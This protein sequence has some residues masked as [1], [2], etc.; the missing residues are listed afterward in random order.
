VIRLPS[1]GPITARLIERDLTLTEGEVEEE[2]ALPI[3]VERLTDRLTFDF[4]LR[5]EVYENYPEAHAGAQ[6]TR[7]E[8]TLEQ[9]DPDRKSGLDRT[10]LGAQRLGLR[11]V[12]SDSVHLLEGDATDFYLVDVE[13]PGRLYCFLLRHRTDSRVVMEA[14]LPGERDPLWRTDPLGERRLLLASADVPAGSILVRIRQLEGDLRRAPYALMLHPR[15]DDPRGLV[16]SL[17]R[18]VGREATRTKAPFLGSREFAREVALALAAEAKLEPESLS[19]ALLE[20]LGH[21]SEAR[22]LALHLLEVHFP[23]PLASLEEVRRQS[24]DTSGARAGDPE[25]DLGQDATLRETRRRSL[26]AGLL[27]AL[28]C[29][30]D[31]RRIDRGYLPVFYECEAVRTADDPEGVTPLARLRPRQTES[32]RERAQQ[33]LCGIVERAGNDPDPQIRLRALAVA[34]RCTDPRL[35]AYLMRTLRQALEDDPSPR[36]RRALEHT[37][38]SGVT[39][40]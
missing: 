12:A 17:F 3:R 20:V 24:F 33:V 39:Q 11:R 2:L 15:E 30:T 23:P 35:N 6:T 9:I 34:S 18:L 36:V 40:R 38:R 7:V 10:P 28:R 32:L 19:L 25:D 22:H 21:H 16:R 26:D 13:E 5:E 14:F 37:F 31:C 27:L 1:P 29:G 4:E 8:L